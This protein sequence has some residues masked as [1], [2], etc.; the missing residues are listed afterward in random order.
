MICSLFSILGV[1]VYDAD[2]RAK[3]LMTTDGILV[4]QIQ[5]EFGTL[6]YSAEGLLN[7]EYL[8][9]T[10]FSNPAKLQ[11]LNAMVH[12]RVGE[13]S[14]RWIS[15]HR[16]FPY[17]V[18]EAALMYESGSFSLMDYVVVVTAPEKL[19]IERTLKRDPLRTREELR[20]IMSSQLSE[21]DKIGRAN[22]QINNDETQLVIPQV[23]KLHQQFLSLGKR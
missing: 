4:Q 16:G 20:K 22:F 12:P 6:S 10:V 15:E 8:A 5:K 19:R 9:A 7:R 18:K 2:S 23:L 14:A 13:D 11:V 3:N 1:P 17:V 21:A